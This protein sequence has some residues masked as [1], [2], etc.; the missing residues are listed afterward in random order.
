MKS[1]RDEILRSPVPVALA[2]ASAGA[3]VALLLGLLTF[4]AQATV[5]PHHLP[6]AVGP[7]EA[8]DAAALAPLTDR[9]AAQGGDAVAW[10]AVGSRAEA[11]R[12]LDRKEVYGALL[13]APAPGG[14]TATVLLSGAVNPSGTQAAQPVLTGAAEAVTSA[15][16]AQAASQP[17]RA[18]A[19][20]APPPSPA[21]AVRLVTIHQTSAAGRLLPLAASAL[22]WL[23]TLVTS[24]LA[25]VAAPAV[26]GGRPLGRPAAVLTALT[27]AGLGTAVALGLARLWDS[28]IPLGWEV[29]GFLAL[30][31]AAF[32]LLQTGVLRWLGIR[33]IALVAPLYLMAPA[34]AGIAPELLDPVYKTWL[35][36][37]TPFRFSAEALRSLLFLGPDAADVAPALW[38][39]GGIAAAGLLLAIA[40]RP[41]LR[42][43]APGA[44]AA[45]RT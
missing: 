3:L 34:I 19:A 36:S 25:V 11:E 21:P 17:G 16:R 23:A 18:A 31:G 6:L 26:R 41:R 20:P 39:F 38:L 33:G 12:L 28:S 1:T 32:A 8:A 13:L 40:P 4:G 35:W 29:A 7:A 44:S 27:A 5:A 22:L 43:P 30:V 15:A 24:A 14:L 45:I 37:W 42:R 9:V 2:L 10:R